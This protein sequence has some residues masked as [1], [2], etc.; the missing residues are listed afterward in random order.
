MA[1]KNWSNSPSKL[2]SVGTVGGHVELRKGSIQEAG[3]L[4]VEN[5]LAMNQFAP[6]SG[7]LE[8]KTM[9]REQ[10]HLIVV[11]ESVP[12]LRRHFAEVAYKAI[13]GPVQLLEAASVSE[14]VIVTKNRAPSLVVIDLSSSEYNGLAVANEIW[15]VNSS[16]KIMFWCH[17]FKQNYF[18]QIKEIAQPFAVYGIVPKSCTDQRL[19]HAIQSI[20]LHDNS[21]IDSSIRAS[22]SSSGSQRRR[23]T[24]TEYE[25]LCDVVQGLTDKAI[26]RRRNL[27]AR[28]VQ[29]RLSALFSKILSGRHSWLRE[30]AQMDVFNLRTRLVFEAVKSGLIDEEGLESLDSELDSWLSGEFG[31]GSMSA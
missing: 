18:Q 9:H 16:T 24:K 31:V 12:T 14:A 1:A 25:T 15:S 6:V 13:S 8:S 4:P 26:A 10:C 7:V 21:F 5:G 19:I 2:E 20:L 22:V 28:G 23:L 17:S 30:S 27:S 3:M 11:L 29:N